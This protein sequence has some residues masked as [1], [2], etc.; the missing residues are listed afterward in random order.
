MQQAWSAVFITA[1]VS[2]FPVILSGVTITDIGFQ[3]TS[4]GGGEPV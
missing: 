1:T 3:A 2:G 4:F